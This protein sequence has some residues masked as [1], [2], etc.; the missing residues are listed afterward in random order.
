MEPHRAS[1]GHPVK[2]CLAPRP[3]LRDHDCRP[4]RNS[5]VDLLPDRDAE[6]VAGWLRR[7]PRVEI[8]ARDR[9]TEYARGAATGAPEAVQVADRWRVT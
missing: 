5:V 6:A 7:H 8:V 4:Q 1:V 3:A 9:S 2:T